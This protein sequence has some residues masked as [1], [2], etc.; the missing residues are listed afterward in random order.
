[1]SIQELLELKQKLDIK[2]VAAFALGSNLIIVGMVIAK[3][4]GEQLVAETMMSGYNLGF[5]F[6]ALGS[7]A[8]FYSRLCR[9]KSEK[10]EKEIPPEHLVVAEDKRPSASMAGGRLSITFMKPEKRT[11]S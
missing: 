6:A 9:K 8:L 2:R 7:I 11:R 1:M 3:I 10:A 5:I 4:C